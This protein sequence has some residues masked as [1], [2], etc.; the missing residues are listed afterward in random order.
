M[1][2]VI[3]V[4]LIITNIYLFLITKRLRHME[5]QIESTRAYSQLA[6]RSVITRQA[7]LRVHTR[8]DPVP[9]RERA[10]RDAAST[11]HPS[12]EVPPARISSVKS[13]RRDGTGSDPDRP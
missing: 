7:A 12:T 8:S 3:L 1:D 5:K 13:S 10:K 2:I 4:L 9:T 6:L 11:N